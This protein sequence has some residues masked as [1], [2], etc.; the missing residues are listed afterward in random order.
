VLD[1]LGLA[2]RAEDPLLEDALAHVLLANAMPYKPPGNRPFPAAMRERFR[3]FIE[4][5]LLQT[6]RGDVIVTLGNDAFHWFDRYCEPG[7]LAVAW[8]RA[9]RYRCEVAAV[10]RADDQRRAIRLCPLPHPSPANVAWA[11]RFPALLRR[12]LVRG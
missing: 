1:A 11:E 2:P 4:R 9:D 12:R 7:A 3:P 5:L 8:K 6:W 10:L